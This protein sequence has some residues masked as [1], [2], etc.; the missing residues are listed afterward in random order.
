VPADT[1]YDADR[2]RELIQDQGTT[3]NIPPKKNRRWKPCSSKR[4]CRER[5]AIE[6]FYSK[7]EQFRRVAT[8]YDKRAA[9][10][11]AMVQFASMRLWLRAND[12]TA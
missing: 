2:N 1:A 10:C 6:P 8:R 9:N 12:F 11:L 3:L 5:N 7:L 4:L